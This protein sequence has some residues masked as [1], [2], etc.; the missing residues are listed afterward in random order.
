MRHTWSK[1]PI[2]ENGY[3]YIKGLLHESIGGNDRPVLVNVETF[4]WSF[5]EA[6]DPESIDLDGDITPDNVEWE[7]SSNAL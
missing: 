4:T 5:D 3:Y 6:D 2:P 7:R 1:G